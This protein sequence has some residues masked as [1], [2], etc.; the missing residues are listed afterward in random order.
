MILLFGDSWARQSWQHETVPSQH[1]YP[2]WNQKN[3]F[4][5]NNVDDWINNYFTGPC[6]N[7]AEF[8]N[9]NNWIIEQ[10]YN[11]TATISN[12]DS[13]IN[14]VVFQTDPLRIFSPR[15]DYT[16]KLVVW[17][18]FT[19]WA[20][21]NKFNWQEQTFTDLLDYIFNNF[22]QALAF[23]HKHAQQKFLKQQV[24]LFILGGVSR[25]HSS[26]HN[27]SLD[28]IH[29]SITNFFGFTQ[30]IEFENRLSLA[31]FLNF[32]LDH[33]SYQ[34]RQ[35]LLDQWHHYENSLTAKEN[36]WVANPNLF[37]GRH[38]TT[39]GIKTVA[40]LIE[41]HISDTVPVV[42]RTH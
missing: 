32:W 21:E 10:L 11:R 14:Y 2:H 40:N 18:N 13:D 23:F 26:V 17:K 29:N 15:L 37:A 39:Q 16:D 36:F 28:I 42:H 24:K 9:T 1:S 25:L 7:F 34:Q 20:S 41:Q 30:D 33:V 3:C 38:L 5:N 35:I 19:N 12:P 4:V 22:Y 6:I 8:G 27:H 31:S